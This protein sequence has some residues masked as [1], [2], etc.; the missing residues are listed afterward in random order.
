MARVTVLGAGAW[1]TALAVVLAG[2]GHEVVLCPRRRALL[3]ELRL[4]RQNTAY[5]PGV[6]LPPTVGLCDDWQAAA[7]RADVVVMAV[8]SRFARAAMAPAAPAI[9]QETVIVSVVKGVEDG[10]PPRTMTQVLGELVAQH[11]GLAVLSGPGFASE[12]ARRKPAALV[13]AAERAELA[14]NVQKLFAS[15]T[16]R[17]YR[18]GDVA[19]VELAAAAKNVIAIA[20]GIS[21]G[22]ELGLS[23]RAAL[24]TRGLAELGRLAV[25]KGAKLETVAGLAGLGDLVLT[26]TGALSRNRALGL[27]LA[28]ARAG[29][30]AQPDHSAPAAVAEGQTTARAVARIAEQCGV[31]MPIVS[32]V[33][34]VLYE[35][36][37]PG[38]MVEELLSR[39]L[40]PEF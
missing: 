40:K 36:A 25:A 4:G 28:R 32:A 22:L 10:E 9:G 2:N 11:A 33:C 17:V 37:S 23:A 39:S 35:G 18:S 6:T 30:A 29:D 24:I 1:G 12:V 16:L 21:D 7:R 5:L 19:G 38:A 20:T 8:P 34:R 27:R 26:C 14:E 3:S 13:A 31:E 15:P